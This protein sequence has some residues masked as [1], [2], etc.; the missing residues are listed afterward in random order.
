MT[1]RIAA[2]ASPLAGLLA[3]AAAASAQ[4]RPAD[5]VLLHGTIVTADSA[6]PRA[7]A[8][9]VSGDSVVAVGTDA[10]IQ[11]FVGRGTRVIDLAGATAL[12]GFIESHGHFIGLGEARM[13]LDLTRATT[14]EEI[15]RMVAE[16]ARTAKRGEWILGRGWHQEKWTHPPQPNV[17][18]LSLGDDL[19]AASPD[20]PVLLTHASGH[21]A[22]VN[23]RALELAGIGPDTKNPPGGEI[24]RDSTGRAIGMLRDRAMGL[25][26]QAYAESLATRTPAEIRA[27]IERAVELAS[28]D[29]LS[30]GVTSFQDQGESFATLDV[31]K[32]LAAQGK[33]PIRL[34]AMVG[35]A[36]PD[37]LAEQL[38]AHKVVGFAR[39]HFTVR[40]I[41]EVTMDGA[42]GTHSAWF[43]EP[44]ADLPSSSG[45]PVTTPAQLRQIAELAIRNGYQVAAHAIGDRAN[46]ETLE[47]FAALE[48]ERPELKTARW[49]IE[50]AQHL[51]TPDIPRFAELG[52]IAS[53]QGIHGCSDG[54]YVVKRLG[55]RRAAEGAYVWRALLAT[56]A[57]IA[58]GTDVPVED[59]DPVANFYCS[60]T[61]RLNDGSEFH[62]EQEMTREEALASYTRAAAYAMFQE[63]RLGSLAPGKLA[64]ITVLDRDIMTVPEDRIPGTRVLYTIVGGAVAYQVPPQSPQ[65]TAMRRVSQLDRDGKTAA[66]R[67]I[68]QAL[69]DSAADPAARAQAQRAMAM[70]YA[71]DGDCAN[72]LKYETQVIAYWATREQADPQ[73]AFYQEG[74]MANEGARVCVDAGDLAQA[75][76]WYRKGYELGVK[77]PEPRTHP[78]SLWDYRLAHAL[79]R[80]AARRGDTTEARRQ[81]AAARRAL[82]GDTA[83]ARDQERYF[84][85]LVGYVALYT[86]DLATAAAQLERAVATRGNERD[87]FMQCLLAMTYERQGRTA[88]AT[89][90]YRKAYDLATAH[91]PPSA[92]ARRFVRQKLGLQGTS[93]GR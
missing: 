85:Y 81:I 89:A 21:G 63:D 74:E 7:E 10:E 44:Y 73:N 20:N 80:I 47:V 64:D 15:V 54:P 13:Q 43:L 84:A 50:H 25:V 14:W 72:T 28:R 53:M 67:V 76:R 55:E 37:V 17:E 56:G 29:A 61:R 12:P 69:I 40:A 35:G 58:N 68:L 34:Y 87:P 16:A 8:L 11:R 57:I 91:N 24:V 77:E 82:D 32:D 51:A 4:Q 1:R 38:P 9:A 92:F 59:E 27:H 66:A 31:L 30:K 2:F 75:E 5:L 36:P 23:R 79:G 88:D 48:R 71:F 3:L 42:L 70:S 49:R 46:H 41:G 33:L 26:R 39:G 78:R 62:P 52:V 90:T 22:Y 19:A 45:F 65:S 86:N 6:R 18:G 83:M 60:I 93:G